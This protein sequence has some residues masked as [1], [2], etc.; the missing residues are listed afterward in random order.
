MMSAARVLCIEDEADLRADIAEELED[1]GYQ[2]SQAGDGR[3]GLREILRFRPNLVVSDIT[4]P[5]LDGFGLLRELRENHPEFAETPF[6]FLSALADRKDQIQ[7]VKMGADDYL[8]KPIDFEI[9]LARVE[10]SLRQAMRVDLKKQQEQVKLYK[11]L[12]QGQDSAP[13]PA[14]D[15]PAPKSGLPSLRINLVG[16]SHEDLWGLQRLLED[17]GHMVTVFTSGRSYLDNQE[18][19]PAHL[20][21]ICLHTDDMQ[22][23]MISR[24]TQDQQGVLVLATPAGFDDVAHQAALRSFG[25]VLPLPAEANSLFEQVRGWLKQKSA[26]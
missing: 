9:M 22:A 15:P 1:A 11:A 4:M 19:F 10:A 3:S 14:Q 12:T 13:L 23:P 20:S 26:A 2:V 17:D 6:I 5:G 18:K 7:G 21:F 25:A 16:V 24:M 8:T